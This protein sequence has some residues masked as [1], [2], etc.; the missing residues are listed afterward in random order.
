MNHNFIMVDDQAPQSAFRE[1]DIA[2]REEPRLFLGFI[3]HR[4]VRTL[5][6]AVHGLSS[7]LSLLLGNYLFCARVVLDRD[8]Q[9][10]IKLAFLSSS[11][12]SAAV[13]IFFFWNKVQS[14]QLSTT[15]MKEKGL[16]A[17]D[18]LNFNRGR[19]TL[20]LLSYSVFPLLV[21]QCPPRYLYSKV[22]SIA[23]AIGMLACTAKTFV[24]IQN[25]GRTL[26]LVYG[27]YSSAV[28]LVIL[29]FG[30]VSSFLRVYPLLID[31]Y[32]KQAYFV[33]SCVQFGF[34]WYY[35]Y[36]RRLVSKEL[37]QTMCKNYHPI[38]FLV[39]ATRLSLD[40]WWNTMPIEVAF[41][42]LLV[43]LFGVLFLI[44]LLKT[45]LTN[46]VTRKAEFKD[47]KRRKSSIFEVEGVQSKRRSSL[48]ESINN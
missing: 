2:S 7:M 17:K 14:W 10:S 46:A 5:Q 24:L 31:H 21:Q 15:S 11:I 1:Y 20:A 25:Y 3:E 35:F 44:K 41:H 37:V 23:M 48:F 12:I 28:G 40:H 45:R 32:E 29:R 22:I 43:S 38:M 8:P 47:T 18:L 33:V 39:Y 6:G 26:F 9:R 16:V 27:M 4:Y 36:S 19:G 30:S 42:S 34:M 13:T